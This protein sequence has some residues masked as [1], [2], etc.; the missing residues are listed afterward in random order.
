MQWQ[1]AHP[2]QTQHR[3]PHSTLR[4]PFPSTQPPILIPLSHFH[5]IPLT[6]APGTSKHQDMS[7]NE[8]E[9]TVSFESVD[10]LQ[11]H[12]I[13][14]L[15]IAKL[16]AA[17]I[18]TIVGVAQTPRKNLLK[19]KGLSEAKVEKLKETCAK[20]LPPPFLTGTEIADKR[21][22]VVYITTGSKSV[23][24]MLGGG[25]ATQSITEIFGE[26]RTGKTQLCHTLCVATQLPED[27]G[28]GA[29]KVAYIDTEGTFRPDRVRAVA[30]RFGVDSGMALDNVLCARAWSSEQ[31]CD[32]LVDLAIRFVEDRSYKLLIVDS[33]MNLFRQDYSGRGELSE[34]QQKLNQ[35]LARLQ[36]LSEEFNLAIVLTNQ[37]QADPGAAA[38]FAAASM[39]K[40]VGGHVLAHASATR[41]ALRKGRGTERIAKLQDSPDMPEGE[42]TYNLGSGGWEDPN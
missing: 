41:I 14:A 11:Q 32:L 35:F 42:A 34:R 25:I 3:Q 33:I 13:N 4:P 37:V 2:A 27:Q 20:M 10:E 22:N 8:E 40:P 30:D 12:G 7:D 19:I 39:A 18:V 17:G 28:G 15:D 26:Y 9:A 1:S 21:Q 6:F 23:D 29:G 24:A 38:M 36:K 5:L 16:K 31:Q